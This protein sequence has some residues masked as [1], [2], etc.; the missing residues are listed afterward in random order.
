MSS[1]ISD[2]TIRVFNPA[3]QEP[4]SDIPIATTIEL[5]EILTHA[6]NAASPWSARSPRDRAHVLTQFRKALAGMSEDLIQSICNETGKKHFEGLLE[7]ITSLEHLKRAAGSASRVLKS[8]SR[9]SGFLKYKRARIQYEPL[10]VA[11]IISPWN[12]PLILSLSPVA[13]ALLAGNTVV[14]KPSEQTPLTAKILKQI[15]DSLNTDRDAFQVIYGAGETGS[16]LV[17][18]PET[19]IICFTGSTAI[20]RRIAED[21]ARQL[22]PVILELGGK[23]PMVVL[24]DAPLERT[25]RAAIWGGMSNA[26]QTCVSVERIYVQRSL[27]GEFSTRLTDMICALSATAD[28]TGTIGPVTIAGGYEKIIRQLKALPEATQVERGKTSMAGWFI[29]PTVVFDPPSDSDILCEETFGP[30]VTVTPF[31]TLEEAVRLAN[32]TGYGLSASVFTRN[33]AHA[34]YF[35][36]RIN[37]GSIVVNDVI[38]GYVIADL[39]FGGKG[40]S[41]FGRVHGEEGLK[42]FS[43]IKSITENRLRFRS[44]PWWY[45]Q[46]KRYQDVLK[47]FIRWYY[48]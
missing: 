33:K 40:L 46:Q 19:D 31:D 1:T 17:N 6:R 48:G 10:G 29:A 47:K 39:P 36:R 15:W 42:A 30:V 7:V 43:H 21:C 45:D 34:D 23:D 9:N 35:T 14:L 11:G 32:A 44:E 38:T 26:G 41:G 20:G 13:E 12:Y 25:L 22:K 18:S 16:C 5:N 8:R 2:Q 28:E 24:N 4:L 27:Y 3:T 37:A